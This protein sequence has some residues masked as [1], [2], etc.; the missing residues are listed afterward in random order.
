MKT[1]KHLFF[2]LDNT[3]WDFKANARQAFY[4]VLKQLDLLARIPD[5]EQFISLYEKYNEHLWIEY[6]KGK[7]K[8]DQMRIE[9]LVLTFN[10]LNIHDDELS[11]RVGDLYLKTAPYKTALFPGVHETLQY[12]SGKYKLYILTNGFS[13]IQI[14]KVTNSG[15]S[16]YFTKL[17]MAEMVGN[18]KPDRRFFE[19]AIK[20]VHAHKSECLMIGD[21]PDADI[22]GAWN[23]GIDQVYFN[24]GKKPCNV[25]PTWEIAEIRELMG[26][27]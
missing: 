5:F 10:E 2:D 14:K 1:Y 18:Q 25:V 21:D 16:E 7:V 6:R 23:A 4:D 8:K 15:L 17:F 22:R 9:R 26:I 24:T 12:L 19:Y 27:L 3:L 13:E 11:E 20:S